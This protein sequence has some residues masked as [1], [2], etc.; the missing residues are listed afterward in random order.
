MRKLIQAIK[1]SWAGIFVIG[2][3]IDGI[4]KELDRGK[5]IIHRGKNG[6]AEDDGPQYFAVK[7][8]LS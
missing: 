7:D 1:S 8:Q 4:N 2:V 5:E 3:L 6:K